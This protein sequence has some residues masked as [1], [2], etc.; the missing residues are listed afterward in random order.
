[1]GDVFGQN[2]RFSPTPPTEVKLFA[3]EQQ[4]LDQLEEQD[5]EQP[6]TAEAAAHRA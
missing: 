1:M 4:L 5:A 3:S 6:K 2:W